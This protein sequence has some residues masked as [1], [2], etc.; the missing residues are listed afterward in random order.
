MWAEHSALHSSTL[1]SVRPYC[2]SLPS[3]QLLMLVPQVLV[4]PQ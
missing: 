4:P 3:D 2:A 1:K